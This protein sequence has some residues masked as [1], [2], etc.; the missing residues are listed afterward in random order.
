MIKNH[1]EI[2]VSTVLNEVINNYDICKCE[3]CLDDIKVMSLNELNPKYFLSS[4]QK[5]E[6]T[7]FL[8]QRQKRIT[9]LARVIT[10]LEI[11]KKNAH[12]I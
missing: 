12:N 6:K 3:D 5:S 10:S 2:L 9:V 4:S 7:A 1:M 8:L 11:V